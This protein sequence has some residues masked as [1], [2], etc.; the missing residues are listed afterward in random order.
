MFSVYGVTGQ[1]FRGTLEQLNRVPGV[2]AARHARASTAKAMNWARNSA[3]RPAA[4]VMTRRPRARRAPPLTRRC[5][6]AMW[7]AIRSATPGR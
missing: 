1:T 6:I 5:C 2:F 7:N 3:S 4:P